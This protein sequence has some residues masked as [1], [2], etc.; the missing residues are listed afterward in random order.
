MLD[1]RIM[2]DFRE[3]AGVTL[4]VR[5]IPGSS[6]P[7]AIPDGPCGWMCFDKSSDDFE[8][9]SEWD[10]TESCR[11]IGIGCRIRCRCFVSGVLLALICGGGAGAGGP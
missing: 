3:A 11:I 9:P 10:P 8:I 1:F 2:L 5:S 7:S 6:P 4:V